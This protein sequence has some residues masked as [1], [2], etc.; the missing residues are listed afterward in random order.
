[1]RFVFLLVVLV[2]GGMVLLASFLVDNQTLSA[3]ELGQIQQ[4]CLDCHTVLLR[5]SNAKRIHDLHPTQSC[6][7]CHA[8][9]DLPTTVGIHKFLQFAGI[10]LF[11]LSFGGITSNYIVVK[12]RKKK[13]LI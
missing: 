9:Q 8:N 12:I 5:Y 7:T 3:S 1:M 11:A 6:T 2:L 10:G 4:N 13:G